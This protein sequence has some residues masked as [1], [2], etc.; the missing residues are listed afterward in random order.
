M[1]RTLCAEGHEGPITFLHYAPD[2][3][4]AIYREELERIAA[5]HP[6]VRLVRSYTRA[7]GAGELDG[8]FGPAHLDGIAPTSRGRDLRLRAAGPAR[9]GPRALGGR[10]SRPGFTSRASC[11]RP[12]LRRA[13]SAEG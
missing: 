2:P 8:H 9:R 4:R 13:A 5:A 11:R 10:G 7:P 12:S 1:L 3:E 6:N